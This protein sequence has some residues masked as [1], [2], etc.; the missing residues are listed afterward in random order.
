MDES[1]KMVKT[2][3]QKQRQIQNKKAIWDEIIGK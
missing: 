2:V 3:E 1:D